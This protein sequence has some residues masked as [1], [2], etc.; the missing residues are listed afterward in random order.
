M[1]TYLRQKRQTRF[2]WAEIG[3]LVLGLL[4]LQ[5]ALFTSLF[6]GNQT[7]PVAGYDQIPSGLSYP[8]LETY[9][10]WAAAHLASLLT[11]SQ[12][13]GPINTGT[14]WA[15]V[16]LNSAYGAST[17]PTASAYG[18]PANYSTNLYG[19]QPV[20]GQPGYNQLGYSQPSYNHQYGQPNYAQQYSLPSTNGINQPYAAN[21]PYIANQPYGA[22]QP[23]GLQSPYGSQSA[24]MAQVPGNNSTYNNGHSQPG[25]GYA[26]QNQQNQWNGQLNNSQPNNASGQ[27]P[28]NNGSAPSTFNP[29]TYTPNTY[30]PNTNTPN[31]NSAAAPWYNSF[32]YNTPNTASSS[33]YPGIGS[34]GSGQTAGYPYQQPSTAGNGGA[35]QRYQPSSNPYQI[36]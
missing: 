12:S 34:Y 6:T 25:Y 31:T 13:Q 22:N 32:G 28:Y 17:S 3:F 11:H 20:Y 5:P 29:N 1:A 18:Q 7:K 16:P 27:Y 10:E 33:L 26:G 23:G 9:K 24:Y 8:S 36:R 4:G 21:P 14:G 30:T 35:W 19:Q 15:P 2:Y